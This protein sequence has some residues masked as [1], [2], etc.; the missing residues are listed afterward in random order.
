ML[1][2]WKKL[3]LKFDFVIKKILNKLKIVINFQTHVL[4]L[5]KLILIPLYRNL[6]LYIA[7]P[8]SVMRPFP[9]P[10]IFS[11]TPPSFLLKQKRPGPFNNWNHIHKTTVCP[12]ASVCAP[13]RYGRWAISTKSQHFP[14]ISAARRPIIYSTQLMEL[15]QISTDS[16]LAMPPRQSSSH[17]KMDSFIYKIYIYARLIVH[18]SPL[19]F[20]PE[21]TMDDGMAI[22]VIWVEFNIVGGGEGDRLS[23]N[24]QQS[25]YHTLL[26]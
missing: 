21:F 4:K 16:S 3:S 13:F 12:M 24:P 26:H 2:Y 20:R 14:S 19:S 22:N 9:M 11:H 7:V 25:K 10:Y 1:P 23:L 15:N 8:R 17:S 18:G 6:D 5:L